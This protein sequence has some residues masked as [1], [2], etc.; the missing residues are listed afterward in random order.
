MYILKY[1]LIHRYSHRS[2]YN[3]RYYSISSPYDESNYNLKYHFSCCCHCTLTTNQIQPL[4]LL[5]PIWNPPEKNPTKKF[6]AIQCQYSIAT[7]PAHT[8]FTGYFS[9]PND[10]YLS[11]VSTISR[12]VGQV[13][14]RNSHMAQGMGVKRIKMHPI[15]WPRAQSE[16]DW[17]CSRCF[18]CVTRA[19][20]CNIHE[21]QLTFMKGD[22]SA[23]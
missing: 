15:A 18:Y 16:G 4:S 10:R 3:H 8:T 22:I 13:A 17:N 14:L 21:R 9:N 20:A 7:G 11:R 1:T 12:A 23:R 2:S 5:S 19:T 6:L